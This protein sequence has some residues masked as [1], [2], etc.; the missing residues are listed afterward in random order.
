LSIL[1]VHDVSERV[2]MAQALKEKDRL[3]ALGML[4][5]GVAHEVNT[6]ITGISSYAQMLLADTPE[7]DPRHGLLKKVE[8][9]TFRA[10][11]IV[12]NLLD[13]ARNR[14]E[15][16]KEVALE[17]LLAECL[18]LQADHMRRRGI[19]VSWDVAPGAAEA[20]VWA[21]EGELH[22]VFANLLGNAVDAMTGGGRNGGRLTLHMATAEAR[23]QVGVRDTGP[24]IPERDLAAIF[25]PFFST[26]TNRGGT[27]LGLAIS[28]GIVEAHQGTL[29]AESRAGCG[30]CFTVELPRHP[31]PA[32]L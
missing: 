25:E 18:D 8:Q 2:A 19:E 15:D 3:A 5:A 26:K 16:R 7:D 31:P 12:N 13:T 11:R 10:A 28:R 23:V 27:G 6:P 29:S 9:Q 4:A 17:P 1:V 24:G 30:A 22:Q 14:H 20:R 21:A 32:A